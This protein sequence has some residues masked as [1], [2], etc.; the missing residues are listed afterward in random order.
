M[1]RIRKTVILL[2]LFAILPAAHSTITPPESLCF[3]SG[4][5][6]YRLEPAATKP[7]VRVRFDN[8]AQNPDL[9]IQMVD[10]PELADFVLADE[11]G[12]NPANPACRSPV[13]AKT[14]TIDG[15]AR[16]PHVT[17]Q[18]S[19]DAANPDFRVYVHSVRY[20]HQDAAALLAATWTAARGRD[21]ADL[22]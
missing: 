20:S 15:K 18:L 4:S 16:D 21:L 2:A 17:V 3:A 14:V 13:P 10:K 8:A 6:T 7:D 1:E 5:A 9:R 19:P 12:D 22:R 11:Y